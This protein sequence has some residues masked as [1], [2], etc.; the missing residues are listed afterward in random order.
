MHKNVT[1]SLVLSQLEAKA[2]ARLHR[3][4]MH[5]T[6]SLCRKV[7]LKLQRTILPHEALVVRARCHWPR[8]IAPYG[9]HNP[10]SPRGWPSF[11]TK[12]KA[13]HSRKHR[14]SSGMHASRRRTWTQRRLTWCR[15]KAMS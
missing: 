12:A 6:H 9:Q 11:R 15:K 5:T 3:I 8:N 7:N 4:Q 14:A 10:T 13:E 2:E 1:A